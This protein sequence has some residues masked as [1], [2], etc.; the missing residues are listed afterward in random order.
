LFLFSSISIFP[1]CFFSL[2][3][4]LLGA[5]PQFELRPLLIVH[6]DGKIPSMRNHSISRATGKPNHV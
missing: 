4:L 5:T 1:S 3:L 2:H 6:T